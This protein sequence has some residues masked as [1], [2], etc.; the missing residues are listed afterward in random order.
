M[1]H[2]LPSELKALVQKDISLSFRRNSIIARFLGLQLIG[3]LFSLSICPQFGLGLVSGHGIAHIFR[4]MGD[5]ACA[6]FCGMLFLSSGMMVAFLGMKGEELWWVWRRYKLT[7]V[8]MP[9]M[10]WGSLMVFHLQT[11]TVFYHITWILSAVIAQSLWMKGRESFYLQ[12]LK[13]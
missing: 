12:S 10:L 2:E 1:K 6:G 13:T 11:E 4:M 7:L 8:L 3:A 5:W 9:P